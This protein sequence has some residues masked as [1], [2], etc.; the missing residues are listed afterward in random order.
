VRRWTSPS[1]SPD[2]ARNA[3][4]C[5]WAAPHPGTPTRRR[6]GFRFDGPDAPAPAL[7]GPA[8]SLGPETTLEGASVSSNRSAHDG[9]DTTP[10]RLNAR[11]ASLSLASLSLSSGL[12][13]LP[14]LRF[15]LEVEEAARILV[16]G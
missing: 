6:H 8:Q 5:L 12:T 3:R 4:D 16:T 13:T 14:A 15:G 1:H 2:R 9:H 7:D 10:S 11:R